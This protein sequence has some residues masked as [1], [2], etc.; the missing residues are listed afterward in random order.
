MFTYLSNDAEKVFGIGLSRTGTTSLNKALNTLG[1][2]SFHWRFPPENRILRFETL[3][4]MFPN[5]KFI[6]T[7]RPIDTW[8]PAVIKHYGAAAPADLKRRLKK[9]A[10]AERPAPSLLNHAPLYHAIHHAL[11]TEHGSWSDAYMAHD[12]TVRAYFADSA[13][14]LEFGLFSHN[15]GWNELCAFL[16]RKTPDVPYPHEKWHQA[17]L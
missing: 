16:N 10:A 6:Y 11:Y 9:I 3:S 14:F 17:G 13:R 5:A 12:R 7:T 15:H 2:R 4:R 1:L 8:V